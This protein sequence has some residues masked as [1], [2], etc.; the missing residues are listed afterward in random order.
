MGGVEGEGV[1][2]MWGVGMGN[3]RRCGGFQREGRGRLQRCILGRHIP[4]QTPQAGIFALI[5]RW[6]K[7]LG[8]FCLEDVP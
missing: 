3:D 1:W 6:Q 8:P 7:H 5:W 2:G 4:S